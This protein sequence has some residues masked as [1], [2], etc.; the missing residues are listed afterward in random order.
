VRTPILVQLKSDSNASVEVCWKLKSEA[1][2]RNENSGQ[3]LI[4]YGKLQDD[5]KQQEA[6]QNWTNKQ[7]DIYNQKQG[8]ESVSIESIGIYCFKLKY[9]DNAQKIW[10]SYSNVKTIYIQ[11]TA[12]PH[13]SIDS[14]IL[15]EDEKRTLLQF[16][17]QR[18]G[19]KQYRFSLLLRSSRDGESKEKF[20]DLC[21]NKGA[22]LVIVKS[23][24]FN[25]V[26]GGYTSVSWKSSGNYQRDESAF[27]F[28]LRSSFGHSPKLIKLKRAI[29]AVYHNSTYGVVMVNH[30]IALSR[31]NHKHYSCICPSDTGDI[32]G[33]ALCGGETYSGKNGIHHDFE[34]DDYEVFSLSRV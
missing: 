3:L 24:Q 20:H 26:F 12:L 33:N 28:L 14:A 27:L 21:D 25:H 31:N 32:T 18:L 7:I 30:A 19:D 5:E 1:I 29:K 8:T 22:T 34:L 4:V 13:N 15:T 10:S 6:Q 2:A 17:K 16:V 9:F 23:K 11:Q